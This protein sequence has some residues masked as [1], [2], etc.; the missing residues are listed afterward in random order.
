[1]ATRSD[2]LKA[3][4]QVENSA[5]ERKL[6]GVKPIPA[7]IREKW[8]TLSRE[9]KRAVHAPTK[10][11]AD[12]KAG[13]PGDGKKVARWRTGPNGGEDQTTNGVGG[14]GRGADG[15]PG[16][17]PSRKSTRGSWA[18]GEKRSAPLTRRA[19]ARVASPEA[20]AARKK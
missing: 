10:S 8:N 4:Q 9:T 15:L 2:T 3:Q 11:K 1:M 17:T 7:R 13:K 14:T 19:Q 5:K 16:K 6:V 12:A 18:A 20:R